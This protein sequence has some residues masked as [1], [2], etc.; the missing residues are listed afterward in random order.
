M[1][2]VF[3][4]LIFTLPSLIFAVE[5]HDYYSTADGT[6]NNQLRLALHGV[7]DNHTVLTYTPGLW[8]MYYDS[9][10]RSN[11]KIWDIYSTCTFDYGSDQCGSY[12]NVCDCYNREH[13]IPQSWFGN[14]SPMVSD[15]FHIYPTDGKV[16]AI[17]G[18]FPYGETNTQPLSTDYGS[19]ALG[20]RLG[21]SSFA[22][23]SGTVFEPDDQYKGDLARTYFYMATRYSDLCNDW[24]NSVFGSN[25]NGL[26][27]YAKNLFLKWHRQDPVSQKEIDRNNAIFDYQHN[28]N[29]FI[30]HPELAEYIWGNQVGTAWHA[31]NS[32]DL[33]NITQLEIY[34]IPAIDFIVVKSEKTSQSFDYEI[35]TISSQITGKN[36]ANFNEQINISDLSSGIYFIKITVNGKTCVNKLI[37]NK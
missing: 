25:N 32:I 14:A 10:R 20:K 22:G 18:N 15:G 33:A 1:K 30:D 37:I 17:R 8:Q 31:T 19:N 28:R 27:D 36:T 11:G 12:T 35:F 7:I 26:T 23:F 34:P 21:N 29:P 4:L 24:G 3:L 6:T 5:P 13:S 2:K 16:N 9:D